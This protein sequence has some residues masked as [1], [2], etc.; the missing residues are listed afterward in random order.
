MNRDALKQIMVDQKEIYLNNPLITREYPLENNVN[1]CFVGIRRTGKSYM[2]YQQIKQLEADGVPMSQ[3]VYVN[4][5]DE[6]LLEMTSDDLN[7]ILEIGLEISGTDVKPYL[8]LDEIQNI[9]GWEKFVRRIADKK[10]R[11][12]I[13]GSNS[14]MLSSEIASTLGGRFVIMNVYPYSFSEYLSAN[15]MEKNYLEVISTKDRAD[16]LSKYNEY[17]TYGAFPELVEIRNKRAFLNSIY[18]T[19]YLGDIIT[20]NKIT[21]DFAIRL[22]LKKIAESV[23]KPLSFSRLTNILK[24]AGTSIGKQ[25]VINYVRYMTDSYLL[26]TLQNYAAKL[27]EKE[28]SPKYYFMDTGLLGLVLLDCKSAQLENLVAI[29]LIRRYGTENVYFFENNVEI[30]FYVPSEK[31]AIQVSMQVLDNMDTK[32]RETRAFVKL[33]NF[34]LDSKCIII[35]NSEEA[36]LNCEGIDIDVVPIWKWLLETNM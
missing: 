22:I 24:S 16:V 26:F 3:I 15:H 5:E 12:N 23:T 17:V 27:V 25:T 13:T 19:V 35:T 20:R 31:L 30:D 10:Y 36:A 32:E 14:K 9:N 2:M 33:N 29:E 7:T 1:Y 6:R 18:Q 11:I 28:T 34:I 21:N 4:F 8:F